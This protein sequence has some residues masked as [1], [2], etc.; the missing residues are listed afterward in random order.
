MTRKTINNLLISSVAIICILNSLFSEKLELSEGLGWDGRLY[1][2]IVLK[3]ELLINNRLIDEYDIQKIFP[4]VIVHYALKFLNLIISLFD[5]TLVIIPTSKVI[6]N[7]FL[8]LNSVCIIAASYLWLKILDSFQ[9]DVKDKLFA[10][11]ALFI[12]FAFLKFAF[13]YAVLTDTFA[14]MVGMLMLY[15]YLFRNNVGLI[16]CAIVG[17]FS[18][19]LLFYCAFLLFIFPTSLKIE[20]T[21]ANDLSLPVRQTRLLRLIDKFVPVVLAF[22]YVILICYFVFYKNILSLYDENPINKKLLF[23]SL[24]LGC[25]YIYKIFQTFLDSKRFF[26]VTKRINLFRLL[27]ILFIF[28]LIKFVANYYSRP[29]EFT[30]S[31]AFI[32]RILLHSVTNPLSFLVSHLFYYGISLSL[33]IFYWH[34]FK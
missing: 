33:I 18:F 10:F 23:I 17:F 1:A 22:I 11:V 19:P 34:D 30:T 21:S 8:I 27:L 2:Y 6:I 25:F 7:S 24:P 9:L 32:T 13:Y 14:F 29:V 3:L 20:T 4:S 12:N 31:T 16:V 5:P 28:L 26:D 15:F